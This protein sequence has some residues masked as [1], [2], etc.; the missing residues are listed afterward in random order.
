MNFYCT[1]ITT[2]KIESGDLWEVTASLVSIEEVVYLD[3]L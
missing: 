1:D 2:T 3:C